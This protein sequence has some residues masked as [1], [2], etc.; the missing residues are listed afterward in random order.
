MHTNQ[1]QTIE[2]QKTNQT[3]DSEIKP[4]SMYRVLLHN[5]DFTPMDFVVDVL[6]EVFKKDHRTAHNIMLTIHNSGMGECGVY[7]H[8]IA[9]TKASVVVDRARKS[10]YPLRCTFEKV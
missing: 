7:P 8:D 9:E 10:E 1:L 4:P 3:T 5:D 2:D 6:V